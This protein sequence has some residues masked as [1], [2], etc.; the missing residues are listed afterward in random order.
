MM[1]KIFFKIS[2][3][4][5]FLIMHG[6]LMAQ[7]P[8]TEMADVFRAEGKIYVVIGVFV[9]IMIVLFIYLFMMDRKIRQLENRLNGED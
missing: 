4:G 1:N 6:M 3:I 7:Q 2:S 9:I 8:E 5:T